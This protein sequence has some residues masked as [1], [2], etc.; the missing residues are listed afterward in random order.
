MAAL[1]KPFD[2]TA[3]DKIESEDDGSPAVSYSQE[4]LEAAIA[5]ARADLMVEINEEHRSATATAL[6]EIADALETAITDSG[7]QL[8]IHCEAVTLAAREIVHAY[9]ATAAETFT[10]DKAMAMI[11]HYCEHAC[12][13]EAD[14]MVPPST[15]K[16]LLTELR[17]EISSR[18]P[19]ASI[20]ISTDKALKAGDIRLA[21]RGGAMEHNTTDMARQIDE[22]FD[23]IPDASEKMKAKEPAK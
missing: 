8:R 1:A 7:S 17:K 12:A 5:E 9:C 11:D 16:K 19:G 3:F 10:S 18:H 14:L 23:A 21:W 22:I 4:Q 6:S 2:Y 13:M 15:P 20:S